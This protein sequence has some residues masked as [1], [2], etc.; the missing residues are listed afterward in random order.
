M[1]LGR[2]PV[3]RQRG[4]HPGR[5]DHGVPIARRHQTEARGA[6][7]EVVAELQGVVRE[8]ADR[9]GQQV[10]E[11]AGRCQRDRVANKQQTVKF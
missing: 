11:A 2:G 8:E 4:R 5:G 1:V 10:R 7:R 6:A 9:G 3:G